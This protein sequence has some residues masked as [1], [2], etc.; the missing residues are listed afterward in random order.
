M[1]YF[2]PRPSCP[3]VRSSPSNP[4]V[5]WK[6][7]PAIYHQRSQGSGREQHPK[8]AVICPQCEDRVK[9]GGAG[10]S[11]LPIALANTWTGVGRV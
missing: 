5:Q 3:L 4:L 1:E 6:H 11:V 9:G 7:A 8:D 2:F 10:A